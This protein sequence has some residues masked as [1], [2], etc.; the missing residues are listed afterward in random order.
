MP[1]LGGAGPDRAQAQ[2]RLPAGQRVGRLRLEGGQQF[3]RDGP[4]NQPEQARPVVAQQDPAA[5]RR[6]EDV[7]DGLAQVRDPAEGLA[8]LRVDAVH[9][10]LWFGGGTTVPG[11]TPCVCEL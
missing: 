7:G 11:G 10:I 3:R 2:P 5:D 8:G 1:L 6:R 9:V 4:V